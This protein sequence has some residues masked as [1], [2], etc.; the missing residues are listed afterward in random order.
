M[1]TITTALQS[2]CTSMLNDWTATLQRWLY[3]RGPVWFLERHRLVVLLWVLWNMPK[4]T[5]RMRFVENRSCFSGT[6]LYWTEWRLP[7]YPMGPSGPSREDTVIRKW[8]VDL[9]LQLKTT[10][11]HTVSLA[12]R[13]CFPPPATP[14]HVQYAAKVRIRLCRCYQ[15]QSFHSGVDFA[16]SGRSGYACIMPMHKAETLI[17]KLIIVV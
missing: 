2:V 14:L 10:P 6:L 3:R 11:D 16:D 13:H 5:N 8:W 9:H 17:K 4:F 12:Q 15:P 7:E 1:S